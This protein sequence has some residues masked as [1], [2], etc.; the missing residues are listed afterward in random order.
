MLNAQT[1]EQLQALKLTAMAATWTTQPQDAELTALSFDERF[2]LLVDA[3]WRTREN[4]RLGRALRDAQ[5]KLPHASIEAIDYPARRELDKAVHPS[6]RRLPA[7]WTD[8]SKSSSAGPPASAT[9]SSPVPRGTGLPQRLPGSLLAGLPPLPRLRPRPGRR[10]LRPLPRPPRRVNVSV[11]GHWALPAPG[12]RTPRHPSNPPGPPRHPVDRRHQPAATEAV[13]QY[14]AD[15]PWRTRSAIASSTCP[16]DCATRTLTA[17]GGEARQLA[18]DGHVAPLRSR[19]PIG[20]F[21]M[22]R[23]GCS[24]WPECASAACRCDG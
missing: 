18:A 13:D 14:V 15:R 23:S 8:T 21:T 10:H 6:A 7:G 4:K 24:R 22:E 1:L 12:S 2:A 20:A 5:L 17:K 16:P 9:P 11:L 19:S 3:E